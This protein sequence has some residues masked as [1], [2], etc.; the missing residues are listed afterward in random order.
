[1]IRAPVLEALKH[2]GLTGRNALAPG[3]FGQ[4]R[5]STNQQVQPKPS[6][7]TRIG[8][9]LKSN[10]IFKPDCGGVKLELQCLAE[11]AN[12]AA[13]AARMEK[14]L[15]SPTFFENPYPYYRYLREHAPIFHDDRVGWM[16]TRYAD[17]RAL[18]REVNLSRGRFERH[19]LAGLSDPVQTAVRPVM[20]GLNLE[21]MRRD[22]P[23]HGRLR[24]LVNRAFTTE[25]VTGLRPRIQQ[26]IDDLL[27]QAQQHRAPWNLIQDFAYPLPAMVIME[28]LGIPLEDRDQVKKWTADRITFLGGI[29]SAPDPLVVA[30][31]ASR[32]A[33]AL[34]AYFK[35]L[36]NERRIRPRDDL[37]S[38]LLAAGTDDRLT[39]PEIVANC[40]LLLT[41]GHET[42]TNLIG[43]G[44]LAL[45]RNPRQ[46]QI[47]RETPLRIYNAID[48][49]LR[50]DCPVQLAPRAATGSIRIGAVRIKEGDRVTLMLGSANRDP[51]QFADPDHL[52]LDRSSLTHLSFGFD[53]HFCLGAH[54]ARAEAELAFRALLT[55]YPAIELDGNPVWSHNIGYR[56]LTKLF[57]KVS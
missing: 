3:A 17:I 13:G 4:N 55:R 38:V 8:N 47:L 44:L 28:L 49:L 19:R 43:N 35:E 32:S 31:A 12:L 30:D 50:Y 56:G 53:R 22:D 2:G 1:M 46:M 45:L 11:Q 16:V 36:M 25:M 9:L 42:T 14:D 39:E 54:L 29:R 24:A 6:K 48:E 57:I 37:L 10:G 26:L 34:N 41:A 7:M 40:S 27:D 33:V 15:F 52:D 18:A 20:D 21:M 5:T 51:D 23:D